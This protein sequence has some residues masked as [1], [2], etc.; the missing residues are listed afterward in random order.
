MVGRDPI[1]YVG[2]NIV[3]LRRRGFTSEQINAIQEITVCS[4]CRASTSPAVER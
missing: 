1:V 4:T 3:G 2:L